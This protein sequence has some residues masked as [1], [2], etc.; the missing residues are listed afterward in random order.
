MTRPELV[1]L[2]H[3]ALWVPSDRFD[4]TVKFYLD[5]VGMTLHWQPDA[6]NIYLALHGDSLALHRADVARVIDHQRSPLDHL[7]FFAPSAAAVEAWHTWML[8][9]AVP[10]GAEIVQGPKTHRDGAT[11]FYVR[12]PAGH[13][14]QLLHLA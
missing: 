11:S 1:G 12:D 6:D 5:A 8:A 10:L 7:G 9:R 14:V 2:R 13:L 4:A 3:L